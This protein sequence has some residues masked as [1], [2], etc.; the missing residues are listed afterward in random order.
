MPPT[1]APGHS[2]A[3][4]TWLIAGA[5]SFALFYV[6]VKQPTLPARGFVAVA[7]AIACFVSMAALTVITRNGMNLTSSFGVISVY[8]VGIGFTLIVSISYAFLFMFWHTKNF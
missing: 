2:I 8:V 1:D 7:G 4:Y 3:F 5:I 6:G